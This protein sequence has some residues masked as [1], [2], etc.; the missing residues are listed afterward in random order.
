MSKPQRIT[1]SMT[2]LSSYITTGICIKDKI[3]G[4]YE[5]MSDG[6]GHG[7]YQIS[8]DGYTWSDHDSADNSHYSGWYYNGGDKVTVEVC[9]KLKQVKFIKNGDE[10][11]AKTMKF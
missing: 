5:F 6:L 11:G 2:N 10:G 8:Y 4:N 7:S 9:P 1:F 3:V